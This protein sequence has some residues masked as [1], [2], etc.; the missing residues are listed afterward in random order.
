MTFNSNKKNLEQN[1]K[2]TEQYISRKFLCTEEN[3]GNTKDINNKCGF[4]DCPAVSEY[5][6]SD[7]GVL[8][9]L[10]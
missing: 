9:G 2:N 6:I 7:L 8:C 3:V 10:W 1:K 5:D 4:L